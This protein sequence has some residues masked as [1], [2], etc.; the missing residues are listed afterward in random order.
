[1]LRLLV[2][3]VAIDFNVVFLSVKAKQEANNVTVVCLSMMAVQ[4][5]KALLLFES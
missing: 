1:M 3:K 5:A 2:V 4:V